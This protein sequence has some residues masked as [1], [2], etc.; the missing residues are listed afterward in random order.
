MRY[1]ARW[2]RHKN[3]EGRLRLTAESAWDL[4]APHPPTALF[5]EWAGPKFEIAAPPRKERTDAELVD[6][7]IAHR[8]WVGCARA[9]HVY[10]LSG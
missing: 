10:V 7:M 4:D 5:W 6:G 2:A 3:E 1:F 9:R 8:L